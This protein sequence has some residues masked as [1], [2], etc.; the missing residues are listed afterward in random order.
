M[1]ILEGKTKNTTLRSWT[2]LSYLF[3]PSPAISKR[4][5][6]QYTGH[7]SKEGKLKVPYTFLVRVQS[8]SKPVLWSPLGGGP[9]SV[10][11]S[12]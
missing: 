8:W 9:G 1:L 2:N 3:K 11:S 6:D 4:M 7:Q 5:E 10:Y 12:S